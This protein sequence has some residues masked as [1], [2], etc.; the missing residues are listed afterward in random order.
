[1]T[2][3]FDSELVDYMHR[4]FVQGH[5]WGSW[6][7]HETVFVEQRMRELEIEVSE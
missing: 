4:C 7:T 5:E 1:M 3:T 2:A 6:C